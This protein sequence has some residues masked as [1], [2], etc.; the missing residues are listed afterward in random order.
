M[1]KNLTLEKKRKKKKKASSSSEEEDDDADDESSLD[2]IDGGGDRK[3]AAKA[4][5][6]K[7]AKADD[8]MQADDVSLLSSVVNDWSRPTKPTTKPTPTTKK[9]SKKQGSA[10]DNSSIVGPSKKKTASKEADEAG[11]AE[12]DA[13][14][15]SAE[16]DVL[17]EDSIGSM[18]AIEGFVWGRKRFRVRWSKRK[19]P[20]EEDAVAV[21]QDWPEEALR[22][23]WDRFR[24]NPRVMD[25]VD[26][27]EVLREVVEGWRDI[28]TYAFVHGW[29]GSHQVPER[30]A[31]L[32]YGSEPEDDDEDLLL[33]IGEEWR[34]RKDVRGRHSSFPAHITPPP[35]SPPGESLFGD[36][37]DELEPVH[38]PGS[39][40]LEEGQG[41]GQ[42][43]QVMSELDGSGSEEE[44][45]VVKK[46]VDEKERCPNPCRRMHDW[47]E[48]DRPTYAYQ[49]G[50]LAR[51][52]CWL[53]G[54]RFM[55]GK[56]LTGVAAIGFY[57][58]SVRKPGHHCKTCNICACHDCWKKMNV[59]K[60][61][62]DNK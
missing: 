42:D 57:W 46:E 30:A 55:P 28:E 2:G 53:C 48:L 43:D 25:W 36:T 5:P 7:R 12:E 60:D 32:E 22:V 62:D 8:I 40:D 37:D 29:E 9:P 58:A 51:R 59:S 26:G 3:Q 41:R 34:K 52:R 47:D 61:D 33:I 49:G 23:I 24:G 13:E 44:D 14:A 10:N 54:V 50:C 35:P 21:I 18:K 16:E 19:K 56:R 39:I 15:G 17:S 27:L 38:P 45:E 6:K 4:R 11:S 20:T 1:L 31:G